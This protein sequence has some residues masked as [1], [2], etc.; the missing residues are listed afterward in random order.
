VDWIKVAYV[1]DEWQALLNKVI[2]FPL[3]KEEVELVT[4]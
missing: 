3:N 4:S 1:M 2:N